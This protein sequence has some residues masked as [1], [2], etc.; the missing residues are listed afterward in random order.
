[1]TTLDLDANL[2]DISRDEFATYFDD[3][4]DSKDIKQNSVVTGSIIAIEG[5]W[6]TVD[7]GY[8]AEGRIPLKQ[9]AGPNGEIT[10]QPGDVVDVYLGHMSEESGELHLSKEKA[11]LM[12]AWD[13]VA[14][15]VEKN[16]T[17]SGSVIARV[18]GGLSVDIGVKAFLPGSQVDLRPVKNLEKLLGETF[19]F[20]IIKF[21]KRRGNIVLSRRVLLEEER[22]AK[23]QDTVGRLRVGAIMNGVIKN[24]TDYGAF[25]DLGGIDGL[26]HITDMSYGRI[27]HPSEMFEVGQTI[28]IKVLKFDAETQRVSLGYKQLRPDPWEEVDYKYPVGSIVRGRVVSIP[29]YGAFVELEDGIEGLVHLSEMTWNRRVKHP[30]K[31]VAVDDT[32][33]AKVLSIDMENKRISLGMKQLE[34]NPWDR[35]EERY[36]VGTIVRGKVRNITD[37][38]IFVGIEDGIDGLVHISDLSW[39]QRL[40]H[41]SDRYQKGDEVEARVLNIDRWGERFSLGIKQLTED[42]WLSVQ[43]RYFLGQVLQGPIVHAA[44]FGVFV[45][46]ED[47]VEGL[48][49]VSELLSSGGD[50]TEAYAVGK[51]LSV[52]ILNIDSRDHKISLSETGAEE[53]VDTGPVS[54]V[55]E[56]IERQGTPGARLGDLMGNIDLKMGEE[57]NSEG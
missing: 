26:L 27:N 21:N 15:A 33:E 48:V 16:E 30:S 4:L 41:P 24:I 7:V 22:E 28:E 12:K 19:E 31:L 32:V 50:W 10:I 9:F 6:V 55:K 38:G 18:K 34:E 13:E 17:V 42:P 25:V 39:G 35:I 56:Y 52:V 14:K 2:A 1:M 43:G 49:H 53:R 20:R 54:D 57:D 46:L 11:D 8:K 37:F 47:G 5:D 36:P 51:K 40:K 45:E 29:D 44:D 23:R 3:F